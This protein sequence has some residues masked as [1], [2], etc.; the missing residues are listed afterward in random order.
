MGLLLHQRIDMCTRIN[1]LA[2]R[3]HVRSPINKLFR[4]QAML[5]GGREIGRGVD[6]DGA[7]LASSGAIEFMRLKTWHCDSPMLGLPRPTY[8]GVSM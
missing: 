8:S 5:D 6:F 3:S 2:R 4:I 7:G 1:G